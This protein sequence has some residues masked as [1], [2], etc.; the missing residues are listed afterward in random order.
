MKTISLFILMLTFLGLNAQD[1]PVAAGGNAAGQNG[2][3]SYS[4][5]QVDYKSVTGSGGVVTQGLQQPYEIFVVG[6]EDN[7]DI[8]LEVTAYP[9]PA[10]SRVN[11]KI[12]NLDI[13]GLFC[14]VYD[15]N[16]RLLLH[17]ELE[18][19]ITAVPMQDLPSA[20]YILKVFNK[21]T[22]KKTFKIIK[23]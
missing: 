18:A 17:H 14:K 5:G 20:T 16:G 7:H 9:N 15:Q 13:N 3:I 12:E 10:V 8:S 6:V 23:K 11:L 4:I 1:G 21:R 19:N 2:S 22:E